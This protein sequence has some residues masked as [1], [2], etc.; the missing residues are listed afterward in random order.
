LTNCEIGNPM[1]QK[2]R[3]ITVWH[4]GFQIGDNID[5]DELGVKQSH[6][7]ESFQAQEQVGRFR[8]KNE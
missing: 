7:S 4:S 2:S 5:A 8:Q 6:F 3:R 1:A